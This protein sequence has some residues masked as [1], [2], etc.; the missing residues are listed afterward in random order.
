MTRI[1]KKRMR[2]LHR[3]QRV[4]ERLASELSSLHTCWTDCRLDE[5]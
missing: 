4:S 1:K 2:H 3:K 5:A